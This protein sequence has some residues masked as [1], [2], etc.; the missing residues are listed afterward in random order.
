MTN[1]SC[2]IILVVSG[3]L[4]LIS[5]SCTRPNPEYDD[6]L[7]GSDSSGTFTKDGAVGA[8]DSF[9]RRDRGV[10]RRDVGVPKKDVSFFVPDARR[11]D[12]GIRDQGL[13]FRDS[14]F[15]YQDSGYKPAVCVVACQYN[16]ICCDKGSGAQCY[17]A[18][19]AFGCLCD[20]DTGKGCP[21]N[22]Q[23]CQLTLNAKCYPS[24]QD[25]P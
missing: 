1:K 22:F 23:C 10:T 7:A 9:L 15:S 11:R 14:G 12:T 16:Q 19:Q 18:N 6:P 17:Q 21:N 5:L 4:C 25:C 20:A 3:F 24:N 2:L 8:V 13:V